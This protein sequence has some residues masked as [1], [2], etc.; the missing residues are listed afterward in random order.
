MELFFFFITSDPP[1]GCVYR[2]HQKIICCSGGSRTPTLLI[3]SQT[4]C[5]LHHGTVL[6]VI[7]TI[8]LTVC[9]GV[10]GESNPRTRDSQSREDYQHLQL[11]Q[12]GWRDSNPRSH[13]PKARMLPTTPHPE[14]NDEDEEGRI[15]TYKVRI[16]VGQFQCIVVCN[17][18]YTYFLLRLVLRQ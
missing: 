15:R 8:F 2:F 3:Q 11:T 17:H 4:C 16:G 5:Q 13:A 18:Q 14:K 7:Y 10:R 6:S 12:S 9:W 1:I